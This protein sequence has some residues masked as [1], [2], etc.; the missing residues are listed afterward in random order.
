MSSETGVVVSESDI[1]L[2]ATLTGRRGASDVSVHLIAERCCQLWLSTPCGVWKQDL[3]NAASV[4][5][6]VRMSDRMEAA[7]M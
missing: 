5:A 1:E 7:E 4:T 3:L 2:A 6:L